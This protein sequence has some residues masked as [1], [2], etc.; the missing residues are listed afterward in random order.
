MWWYVRCW[1]KC[2]R[3]IVCDV[4]VVCC[5]GARD[6]GDPGE[7]EAGAAGR[8]AQAVGRPRAQQGRQVELERRGDGAAHQ[9]R[10]PLPRR[11]RPE[12]RASVITTVRESLLGGARCRSAT[13][14]LLVHHFQN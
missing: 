14:R 6:R 3:L 1:L 13:S 5:A 2:A 10:Q 8:A 12:V 7:R 4:V 9:G 11:H